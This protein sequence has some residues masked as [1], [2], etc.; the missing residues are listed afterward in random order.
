MHGDGFCARRSRHELGHEVVGYGLMGAGI[1]RSFARAGFRVGVVSRRTATLDGLPDGVTAS[2]GLLA[3]P[4]DIAVETVAEDAEA[5]R[6]VY[7]AV[8]AAYPLDRSLKAL[9]GF[10]LL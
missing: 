6:A 1:V 7:R 2:S 5:K 10:W 9:A 4:P 8:G 3:G